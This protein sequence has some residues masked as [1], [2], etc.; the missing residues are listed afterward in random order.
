MSISIPPAADIRKKNQTTGFRPFHDSTSR[1]IIRKAGR[2]VNGDN[3]INFVVVAL[4]G[5]K[6]TGILI[7][8]L[9]VKLSWTQNYHVLSGALPV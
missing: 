6:D 7:N 3:R 2:K 9:P 5:Y 8:S 4:T 1:E